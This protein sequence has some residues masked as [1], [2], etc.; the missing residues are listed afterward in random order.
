MSEP[1]GKILPIYFV[2]DESASMEENIDKLNDG[3]KSLLDQ[4]F[5]EPITKGK[6]R[7]SIIGFGTSATLRLPMVDLQE[8]TSMPKL[9]ASGSTSYVDAFNMLYE[10]IS[11]DIPKLQSEGYEVNRPAVFFLTDGLPYPENQPWREAYRALTDPA[12]TSRPNILAFGVGEAKK[13][14]IRE[15]ATDDKFAYFSESD[16]S[17]GQA[18]SR[19]VTALTKSVIKSAQKGTGE[20]ILEEPTGFLKIAQEII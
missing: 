9:E 4:I 16:T 6:A 14:I 10:C 19:F 20:L 11:E 17:I 7:F 12:F 18:L 13:D 3:L 8:Q 15:I 1:I 5:G 2:A